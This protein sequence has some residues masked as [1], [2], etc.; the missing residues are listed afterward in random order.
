M[1]PVLLARQDPPRYPLELWEETYKSHSS[2]DPC[3][4]DVGPGSSWRTC[5]LLS[6]G[7]T[8]TILERQFLQ[9]N[10]T[11]GH[12]RQHQVDDATAARH[13]D[14]ADK[15]CTQVYPQQAAVEIQ[16]MCEA[17]MYADLPPVYQILANLK[18]K[19]AVIAIS[20]L[21]ISQL[22]EEWA[23]EADS[24]RVAPVVT[25][26]MLSNVSLPSKPAP[27]MLTSL[28]LYSPCSSS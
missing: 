8:G 19:E 27:P 13:A 4:P 16:M 15:E 14:C 25:P 1:W 18:K 3:P 17:A 21:A 22:L 9:Q 26:E 2:M 11:L 28:Q 20:Q 6:A 24:N 7:R 23:R 10:A 12:L 5:C